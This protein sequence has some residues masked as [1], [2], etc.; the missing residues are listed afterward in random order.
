MS[1][2]SRAAIFYDR[3]RARARAHS[4]ERLDLVRRVAIF[5]LQLGG[6]LLTALSKRFIMGIGPDLGVLTAAVRAHSARNGAREAGHDPGLT[7]E[8]RMRLLASAW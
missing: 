2:R 6:R 7:V 1:A 5:E 8:S 4:V 3:G